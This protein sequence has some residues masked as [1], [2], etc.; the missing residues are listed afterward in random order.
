M[1]VDTELTKKTTILF[2]PELYER[3]S[4]IAE[5]RRSSV[6]QLVREACRVQYAISTR[7]ERRAMVDELAS[8]QLPAGTP[9][10][11]ERD[12]MTEVKSFRWCGT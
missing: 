11:M 2:R 10:E 1:A 5:R 9:E 3:L 6:S 8:M 7:S 4:V 12:S